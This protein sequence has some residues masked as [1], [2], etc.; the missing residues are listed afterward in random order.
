MPRILLQCRRNGARAA[1]A[2]PQLEQLAARLTPDNLLAS[3]PHTYVK[4]GL[5]FSVF[6]HN[7][8]VQ[9]GEAAVALGKL[10]EPADSWGIP[11]TSP[12][13]GTYAL[14]RGNDRHVELLTDVLASRSIWYYFDKELFV[15]SSSQRAIV[16]V[17][18][19]FR[20][21]RAA[22]PWM[23]SSGTLGPGI[24]WDERIQ[25]LPGDST[26]VL[27]RNKWELSVR[28][29]PVRF[30]ASRGSRQAHRTALKTALLE[31]FSGINLDYSRWVLPLSGG[32]D[33]RFILS[34]LARSPD[35]RCVTW[36]LKESLNIPGND[37]WIAAK[38]ARSYGVAHRYF[39]TDVSN[40]SADVLL[41]RFLVCGEGRSDHIGGYMDG[42]EIWRTLKSLGV[43]GVI[44]GDEG[45]GWSDVTSEGDVRDSVGLL[46]LSDYTEWPELQQY[47]FCSQEV[48]HELSRERGES[49]RTWRDRLYHQYRVPVVLAA[50]TD[51][52]SP[53]VEIFNPFL[54]RRIIDE[55]RKMPDGLRSNK[56]LFKSIVDEFSPN[57]GYASHSAIADMRDILKRSS[58]VQ[59]IHG[60]LSRP[61]ARELFG[62][63]FIQILLSRMGS[64]G[65]ARPP[66]RAS[67]RRFLYSLIPTA[68]K[69]AVKKRVSGP[70]VDYRVWGFRAY[71]V[72]RMHEML[73]EDALAG[74][75]AE[76]V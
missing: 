31:T 26:L 21:N 32:H 16:F 28:R 70:Q 42:F 27:D 13:D 4:D 19:S 1:T 72:T 35:L 12:P 73:S 55:V 69:T 2:T 15:A 38:V 22:I 44:R 66:G 74:K 36:G 43:C 20:P 30:C 51:L 37:A 17:M 49:L 52:K 25:S 33:S 57:V 65:P 24:S 63:Q 75:S 54:S 67:A 47:G 7:D 3:H 5:V 10:T 56:S 60:V 71:L 9:I 58:F 46:L 11:L 62:A 76:E 50:L 59:Q 29:N 18:G 14:F 68:V 53:Y 40:E 23:L 39:P 48:P 34:M 8:E 41:T 64:I 61:Y 6:H 45:F